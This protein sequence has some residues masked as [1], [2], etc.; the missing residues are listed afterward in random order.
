M[1]RFAVA[2][3]V[4]CACM[5][6]AGCVTTAPGVNGTGVTGASAPDVKGKTVAQAEQALAAA[7]IR[8][9]S[10]AYDEGAVGPVGS[11]VSQTAQE[12]SAVALTVAGPPPIVVPALLGLD[13]AQ[14]EA[15]LHGAGLDLGDVT[16]EY[17]NS[18]P[19]GQ[20][21]S[22]TPLAAT[23]AAKGSPISLVISKGPAPVVIPLVKGKTQTEATRQLG[24][25]GFKVRVVKKA[26]RA[27][28][29]IVFAQ[30]PASGT[31]RPG[32]TVSISVSTGVVMVRVPDL[33]GLYPDSR[34]V[35]Y[36]VIDAG[37]KLRYA[38]GQGAKGEYDLISRLSPS[39][40]SWIPKGGTVTYWTKPGSY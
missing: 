3:L 35:I 4:V 37:V 34:G 7:G 27:R 19:A 14:A 10:V 23:D 20:V 8:V 24:A 22:Q 25:A 15:A 18:A 28:K 6:L 11:I 9:S 1:K 29:G 16:E 30:K 33:I 5:A 38:A 13:R 2:V 32:M 21:A 17:S 26:N 31:L 40:G 39:A 12:G 36:T